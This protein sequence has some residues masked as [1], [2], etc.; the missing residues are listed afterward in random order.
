[1]ATQ[2]AT[3]SRPVAPASA[4]VIL[5]FVYP[6][7]ARNRPLLSPTSDASSECWLRRWF[8]GQFSAQVSE[9][10]STLAEDP[11]SSTISIIFIRE[12]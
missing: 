4:G 8:S 3:L 1:M 10:L 5:P 2:A 11:A 6:V 7:V 9:R 12:P